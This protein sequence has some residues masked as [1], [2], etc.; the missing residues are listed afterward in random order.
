M[1]TAADELESVED[2]LNERTYLISA[3]KFKVFRSTLG[4]KVQINRSKTPRK[5][6][7]KI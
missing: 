7:E 1:I 2:S 4:A 6:F 5:M 3:Q